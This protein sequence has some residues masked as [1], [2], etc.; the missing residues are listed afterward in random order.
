MATA[1]RSSGLPL[2]AA[3]IP[4]TSSRVAATVRSGFVAD[5]GIRAHDAGLS[6]FECAG[7]WPALIATN[8]KHAGSFSWL[9]QCA[10]RFFSTT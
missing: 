2:S 7:K 3:N 10:S 6:I 1:A 4:C 8:S 9:E 5:S